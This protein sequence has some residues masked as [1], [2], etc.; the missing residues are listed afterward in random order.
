MGQ[1]KIRR[2][3]WIG[4]LLLGLTGA[5][6]LMRDFLV[7][8]MLYPAPWLGVKAPQ[9][10]LEEVA[11]PLE[12]GIKVIAWRYRHPSPTPQTPVLIFFH[13]NAENLQTMAF[14]GIF[15]QF[16]QLNAHFLALDY[17]GYGRS[18]GR[19]SEG[20]L[21]AAGMAALDRAETDF[22][23]QPVILAG[24]SLGAGI[25]FQVAARAP[26]RLSGF[27]ALSAW[28]SLEDV[29]KEHFPAWLVHALLRERYDSL[30]AAA[31]IACP[32]LLIHGESDE[33]IP[34]THGAA[35]S[36]QLPNLQRWLAVPHTGHNDLF[37][38]REVWE[39]LEGFVKQIAST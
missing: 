14:S 8:K 22:P 19:P 31:Q 18:G 21:V 39:A 12:G 7:G 35:L 11:L 30:A 37:S 36:R 3:I 20:S 15:T 2:K 1:K 34:V 4:I 25:A 10:P 26:E 13:G 16:Q 27:I 32:A 6:Y 29:A 9:A 38:R 28:S 23:G 24:W 17:P 33:L 5:G